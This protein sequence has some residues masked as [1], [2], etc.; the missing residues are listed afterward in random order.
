MLLRLNAAT[1]APL[2]KGLEL[3]QAYMESNHAMGNEI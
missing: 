2:E 3:R 1:N